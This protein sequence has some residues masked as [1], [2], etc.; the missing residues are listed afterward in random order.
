MAAGDELRIGKIA[1]NTDIY[2]MGME[3]A[4]IGSSPVTLP[5]SD[6]NSFRSNRV[7]NNINFLGLT[8][9]RTTVK[10]SSQL[11]AQFGNTV[12]LGQNIFS[13]E[14]GNKLHLIT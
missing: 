4:N 14:Q 5:N 1:S 13:P 2:S 9:Q 8:A 6:Y 10:I 11:D 7:N 3:G 12:G